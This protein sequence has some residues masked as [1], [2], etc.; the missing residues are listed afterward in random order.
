MEIPLKQISGLRPEQIRSYND[1]VVRMM[2]VVLNLAAAALDATT[3][4]E[5]ARECGVSRAYAYAECLAALCGLDTSGRDRDLFRHYFVPMIHELDPA[6]F[7]NDAY[8]QN[9]KITPGKSGKW[10]YRNM[11][12]APCEAFVCNDFLV[13][14]DHRMI[15]QIGFFMR[16]FSFPG[17]LEN[18][19]EWM[20]LMPNET[21][22]TRPALDA[23]HGR[24]LTFGLGLGYFAYMAARKPEVESVTVVDLSEDAIA[25]FE[26]NLLPQMEC[27]DKIKVIHADAFA[28]AEQHYPRGE[29]DFVFADIWHDVSDGKDL[30]LRFKSLEK[31]ASAMEF[32]Y[33]LEESIKCYMDDALWPQGVD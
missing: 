18:G 8:Y 9:I 10:E 15:P 16:E 22:T 3:V 31:L 19:R 30:Y 21:V 7:E 5:I 29:F 13:T 27:G 20:T 14:R 32:S 26:Q 33:W 24:V 4:D 1:G 6:D 12:L 28:F 17:V 11:Q 23:A 2:S 25:L